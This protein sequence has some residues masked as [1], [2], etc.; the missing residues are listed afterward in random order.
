MLTGLYRHFFIVESKCHVRTHDAIFDD[1]SIGFQKNDSL[2]AVKLVPISLTKS[3]SWCILILTAK[4]T[5]VVLPS[6]FYGPAIFTCWD[7]SMCFGHSTILLFLW[8]WWWILTL[9]LFK[10]QSSIFVSSTFIF[11]HVWYCRLCPKTL[12][13]PIIPHLWCRFNRLWGMKSNKE[14]VITRSLYLII[15]ML[16]NITHGVEEVWCLLDKRLVEGLSCV[17]V[18][19]F[20]SQITVKVNPSK[21]EMQCLWCYWC[22]KFKSCCWQSSNISAAIS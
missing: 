14:W 10:T 20:P 11:Y 6:I 16:A 9:T 8:R 17:Y 5:G 1:A 4:S 22:A 12:L 7:R 18:N 15:F 2:Y 3:V 13:W 19:H 21:V